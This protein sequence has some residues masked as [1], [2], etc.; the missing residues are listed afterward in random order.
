M[1]HATGPRWAAGLS[2]V[3]VATLAVA[4]FAFLLFYWQWIGTP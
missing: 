2:A 4:A 3:A 1:N